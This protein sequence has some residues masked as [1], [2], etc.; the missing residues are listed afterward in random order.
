MMQGDDHG[1]RAKEE[2]GL[3]ER[4]RHQVEDRHRVRGNAE[5][6]R[7]VAQLRQRRV[8][9]DALDVVLDDAEER[10][11]ERGRGADDGDER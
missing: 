10:H 11:K 5:R 9:D 1:A 3:E 8:C 4:V 6:D 2:Q 7:H